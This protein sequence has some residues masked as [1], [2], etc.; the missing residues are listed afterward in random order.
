MFFAVLERVLR[1][2]MARQPSQKAEDIGARLTEPSSFSVEI[3]TTGVPKYRMPGS[4]RV[5]VEVV[6][7]MRPVWPRDV[8]AGW[9]QSDLS[10]VY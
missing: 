5:C 8:P 1:P 7:V 6:A 3:S 2:S 9:R 4:I 10:F